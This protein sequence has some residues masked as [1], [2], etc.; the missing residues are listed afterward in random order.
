MSWRTASLVKL[1]A[2]FVDPANKAMEEMANFIALVDRWFDCCNSQSKYDRKIM[3]SGFRVYHHQQ[4]AVMEEMHSAI[5]G[6]IV[7]GKKSHM[8]WQTGILTSTKALLLLYDHLKQEHGLEYILT[9]RIN[10]DPLEH[11][12][13][14]LRA[15]GGL[16]TNPGALN[17][18]RRLRRLILGGMNNVVIENS[19]VNLGSDQ[20]TTVLTLKD[21]LDG[22]SRLEEDNLS[23]DINSSSNNNNNSNSNSNSN[24]NS[25]SSNTGL[26]EEQKDSPIPSIT[27][28]EN[29]AVTEGFNYVCGFLLKRSGWSDQAV[30]DN[31]LVKADGFVESKWIDFL[32]TGGLS[33]PAKEV[34][35]DVRK[36]DLEFERFHKKSENGLVRGKNITKSFARHLASIFVGYPFNFLE[37]F[38]F[39]RTMWRMR[40]MRLEL[41]GTKESARSKKKSIDFGY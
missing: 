4:V 37:K 5:D 27:E 7:I 39:A 8:I 24:N 3:R 28:A 32:N 31:N 35:E 14:V 15:M 33:Y 38:S 1:L 40:Q 20:V 10:Q 2:P 29:I 30:K 12:F 13:S 25:N 18:Q 23:S 11:S 34:V 9:R 17:F 36:M 21:L 22:F 19:L 16:H 26:E 41:A 6:L